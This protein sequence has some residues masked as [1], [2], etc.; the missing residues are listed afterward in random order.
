[1]ETTISA[2]IVVGRPDGIHARP[3]GEL[4]KRLQGFTSA[5]EFQAG[6]RKVNGKSV[7]QLMTL[8]VKQG[9]TLRVTITGEDADAA[10]AAIKAFLAGDE[11]SP[12]VP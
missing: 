1:M 11:E 9:E 10:L 8:A 2:E 12:A 5:V 3:A 7:I 4:I 6:D